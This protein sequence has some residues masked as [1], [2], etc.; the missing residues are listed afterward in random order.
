M[1]ISKLNINRLGR[2]LKTEKWR[3]LADLRLNNL[4]FNLILGA[5]NDLEIGKI[6]IKANI[7]NLSLSEK[8]YM[9]FV[10]FD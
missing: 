2:L 1:V 4:K 8:D 10:N 9:K 3:F 6:K 7:N 5:T